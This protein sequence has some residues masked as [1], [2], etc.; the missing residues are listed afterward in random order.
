[1]R[2]DQDGFK[3]AVAAAEES[4][5]VVMA[6]GGN[7]GWVNVTG[8]EGKDRQ[9]LDLPGVQQELLEAVAAVGKPVVL[10]LYG[11][12]IFAVNWAQEHCDAIIQAFMPGPYAG[13]VI[14]DA[15]DGTVN[16]GGKLTMTV[17]RTT[18]QL[19]IYYNHRVGSGYNTGGDGVASN[20]IHRR[21]CRRSC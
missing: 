9:F 15:L 16:P 14:S 4:D 2:E 8:G 7:S 12:G 6:C 13:K 1:M 17:P 3:E 10:V 21:L 20:D 5:V 18:G 11:P 19:P